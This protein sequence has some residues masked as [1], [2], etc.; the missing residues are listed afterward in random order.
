LA[1]LKLSDELRQKLHFAREKIDRDMLAMQHDF[2]ET[3]A[4]N[5]LIK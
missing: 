4:K 1:K 5:N 2:I 3:L